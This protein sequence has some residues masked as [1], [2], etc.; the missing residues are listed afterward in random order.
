[1]RMNTGTHTHAKR[2]LNVSWGSQMHLHP[3]LQSSIYY[4]QTG[5][6]WPTTMGI[7]QVGIF[8]LVH[9]PCGRPSKVESSNKVTARAPK[10]SGHTPFWV[11]GKSGSTQK[12]M[13]CIT[14]LTQS[15]SDLAKNI[16]LCKQQNF[17][18]E[19]APLCLSS[20]WTQCRMCFADWRGHVAG[21]EHD[22]LL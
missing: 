17:A 12:M 15:S 18:C 21:C 22:V 7:P 10:H 9:Y 8:S 5:L 19:S 16:S 14:D 20:G 11:D 3:H 2:Q 6:E 4:I 13:M 1:M